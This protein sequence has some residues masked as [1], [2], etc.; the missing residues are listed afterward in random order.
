[1]YEYFSE[2]YDAGGSHRGV[3]A[4]I[5]PPSTE[6]GAQDVVIVRPPQ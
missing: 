1:M 6:F 2:E 3:W 5:W 4:R